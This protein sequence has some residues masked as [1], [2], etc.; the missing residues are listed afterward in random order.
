MMNGLPFVAQRQTEQGRVT[1]RQKFSM[2]SYSAGCSKMIC[3]SRVCCHACIVM[4]V[5]VTASV[6][7]S[8]NHI[9][10]LCRHIRQSETLWISCSICL[11]S[12][13][14][15]A[16]R[17]S[18]D[19]HPRSAAASSFLFF[20]FFFSFHTQTP[21]TAPY[22]TPRLWSRSSLPSCAS[23]RDTWKSTTWTCALAV[24]SLS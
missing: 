11:F 15:F 5:C 12:L 20:V 16:P 4:L 6:N 9:T 10:S 21:P 23:S 13:I 3:T 19:F 1:S 8:T 2:P 24:C 7:A 17:R 22:P 14:R 18:H